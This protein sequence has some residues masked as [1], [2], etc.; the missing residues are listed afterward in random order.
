[1]GAV[2]RIAGKMLGL[3]LSQVILFLAAGLV[4]FALGARAY[5]ALAGERRR[6][7]AAT[8]DHLRQALTEAQ[9][10]RARMP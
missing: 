8:L 6:A 3:I 1:M 4:G 5:E 10:R 7:E 2:A 9:V